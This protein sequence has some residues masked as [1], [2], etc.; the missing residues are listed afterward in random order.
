MNTCYCGDVYNQKALEGAGTFS[1]GD[2]YN[3]AALAG[4]GVAN[5]AAILGAGCGC[6]MR[7]GF[8]VP[9]GKVDT[10][11]KTKDEMVKMGR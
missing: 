9:S 3:S 6:G 1:Y 7:G 4:A 10:W 8:K 11:I 2:Y 5:K